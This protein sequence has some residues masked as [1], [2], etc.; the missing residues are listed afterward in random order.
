LSDLAGKTELE[1][2]Q[3]DMFLDCFADAAAPLTA[4]FFEKDE[5]KK[6]NKRPPSM[7]GLISLFYIL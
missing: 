6:V 2:A 7:K 1:K 4:I 5:A 3:A